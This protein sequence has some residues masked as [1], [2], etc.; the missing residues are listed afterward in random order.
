MAI[1]PHKWDT[2]Q[3]TLTWRCLCDEWQQPHIQLGN[4]KQ[5]WGVH[6][7]EYIDTVENTHTSS[8]MWADWLYTPSCLGQ[9]EFQSSQQWPD[10]TWHNQN[11]YQ[12]NAM[13]FCLGGQI[14]PVWI[15]VICEFNMQYN[16]PEQL[17]K[18]CFENIWYG[19]HQASFFSGNST[20][21]VIMSSEHY[22]LKIYDMGIIRHHFSVRWYVN[23]ASEV[24]RPTT[25]TPYLLSCAR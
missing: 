11:W 4:Q 7:S 19:H 23:D 18:Q 22:I 3:P 21:T 10:R 25:K 15:I 24:G 6:F 17:H 2:E 20:V 1:I 8:I 12:P 9:G 13:Y 16:L 5:C 14:E